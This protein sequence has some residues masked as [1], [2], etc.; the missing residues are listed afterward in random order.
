[1]KLLEI[2]KK[3]RIVAIPED[4]EDLMAILF[5]LE[6]GAKIGGTTL[7]VKTIKKGDEILKGDREKVFLKIEVEKAQFDGKRVRVL[8]RIV[9]GMDIGKYHS[10]E[11]EVGKKVEIEK[12]F[13][14]FEIERLK[15]LKNKIKPRKVLICL[16]DDEESYFGILNHKLKIIKRVWRRK[17]GL[18]KGKGPSLEEFFKEVAANIKK[19]FEENK[20]QAC[21]V[22][23]PGFYKEEVAKLL[24]FK[25]YLDG[26]SYANPSGFR[27]LLSRESVK[28]VAKDA[29][30]SKEAKSVEEF[31]EIL[32][33]DESKVC[34]G[35]E[36]ILNN[37]Q[38]LKKVIV[39]DNAIKEN[40]DLLEEAFKRNVE[41]EIIDSSQEPG[42]R[43]LGLK[44]IV[45][46]CW[47]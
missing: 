41:I 5:L 15:R 35:R 33:K 40:K 22:A 7:R 32:S 37:L 27:E 4:E 9:E 39:C 20:C 24:D 43:I 12:E 46:L 44:G 31:F 30:I 45:G 42:K 47:Y 34:I 16:L 17:R 26:V 6:K 10:M 23:S 1:M 25:V 19:I 3:E 18:E 36:D 21:I 2:S 38:R 8:G 28:K 29:K 14:E 11:I 13:K